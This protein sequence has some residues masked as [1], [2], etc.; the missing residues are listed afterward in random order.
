VSERT[1]A[2]ALVV[3]LEGP[4]PSPEEAAW[5]RQWNPAGVILFARNVTGRAQLT[6]LCTF[7]HD[8]VPTLEITADHEG[9]PIS[10]LAAAVGCP[11][12]PWTLGQ[13]DDLELTRKVHAETA[14]RLAAVGVDRVLGPCADVLTNP[15]NPVI[16]VR[17]FGDQENL[18]A[19]HV[20]AAVRGLNAGGVGSCLKH[21]PGHGASGTDSHLDEAFSGAVSTP[22]PFEAGMRAGCTAVMVG[23]LAP[24]KGGTP[25]TLDRKRLDYWRR[26]LGELG[27][28]PVT[29]WADDVTMGALRPAMMELGVPAP[30]G[31]GT[32]LVAPGDLPGAWFTALVEAG[33]DRLLIRG[34][35]WRAFPRGE[36]EVFVDPA[37]SQGADEA[38]P[39]ETAYQEARER[40]GC[41]LDPG[42]AHSEG[43]VVWL[44]FTA[45]DRWDTIV[46]DQAAVRDQFAQ[47]LARRFD[48][49]HRTGDQVPRSFSR[50]ATHLV[51]TSHRPLGNSWQ[52]PVTWQPWLAREGQALVSGHP[53]L[54]A[55]IVQV[56]GPGWAV[57]YCPEMN[58]A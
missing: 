38:W 7:L 35:P 11:P 45:G 50:P 15:R 13:V 22:A 26:Q 1:A 21:W 54:M 3:G 8:L 29:L 23:H 34:I 37:Q 10:H 32:G 51:V 39:E 46:P 27:T 30:D 56:L 16:G 28:D 36:E 2:R 6:R 4:W 43:D 12:A 55:D 33:C 48:R 9:G 57:K 58:Y 49:V 5:L 44:D 40:A 42:F 47:E 19:R 52:N 18:V 24:E 41:R 20:H 17:A 25:A 53:S 31:Q 14:R